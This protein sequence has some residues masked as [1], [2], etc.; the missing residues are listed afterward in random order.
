MLKGLK[1]AA[2]GFAA[3]A[4]FTVAGAAHAQYV[5]PEV[6]VNVAPPPPRVEVRTVAPSPNH[7]WING[8][9]AWRYGQHTWIPG[10][11]AEP[12]NQGMV[13]EPARWTNVGGRWTFLEGHWRWAAPQAQVVWQPPVVQAQP[14]YVQ[15]AP[16]PVI[17][18]VRVAAP[19]AGAVWIPG[20]WHWNGY[21]HVW[22]AG[23]WSA[24]R[25]GYRW[26]ADH[27]VHGPTGWYR[28]Q[29]RWVQ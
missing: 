18:E 19:Y 25:V 2:A 21:S 14:V 10:H 27:W 26:E 9:W 23:H 5:V 16:P 17:N 3:A 7:I 13:Y 15:T 20:Y 24:P 22:V 11:W 6:Q 29:G 1:L 8:H 28:V 4:M 12:P